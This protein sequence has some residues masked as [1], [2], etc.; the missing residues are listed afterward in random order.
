MQYY[1]HLSKF[2]SNVNLKFTPKGVQF[3]GYSLV[4][5]VKSIYH[6]KFNSCSK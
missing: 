6:R 3:R 2:L 5:S 1:S 4:T